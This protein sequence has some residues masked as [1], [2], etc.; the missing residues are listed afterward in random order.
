MVRE[1]W[2]KPGATIIDVGINPVDVRPIF[3]LFPTP[4]LINHYSVVLYC[5]FYVISIFF[6]V[7]VALFGFLLWPNPT[8]FRP[9]CLPLVLNT[10]IFFQSCSFNAKE[11]C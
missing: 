3:F 7:C 9:K 8:S 10:F 4:F 5:Y 6:L 2:I 1:N 11:V